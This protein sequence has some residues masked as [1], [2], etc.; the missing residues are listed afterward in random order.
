MKKILKIRSFNTIIFGGA[1]DLAFRKIYPALFHRY[2]DNQIDCDFNIYAIT[3]SKKNHINF[4]SNL[5]L[6]IQN[7]VDY[8]LDHKK[9]EDFLEKIKLINIPK[10][11]KKDYL[12]LKSELNKT[13]SFQNIFYFSTPADAFGEISETL[14]KC[15]LINSRSKVV[16]EKPLGFSLASSK[17]INLK[18][19]KCFS[20]NQIYRIDHYLG[21]ETVQNLMV[22]RFANSGPNRVA[23]PSCG[24]ELPNRVAEPTRTD[25]TRL[26]PVL[27]VDTGAAQGK[28]T[29]SEK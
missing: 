23:E 17:E 25:P 7:S 11:T 12:V 5:K 20:E 14:K 21:K 29:I 2:V 6:S 18:I 28:D 27:Q 9:I 24:S 15:Q 16:L 1:G 19:S 3:R 26:D 22:L 4:Y 10:H 13:P 8:D